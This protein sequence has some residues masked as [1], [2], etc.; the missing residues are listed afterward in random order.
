[1][2]K[3][4]PYRIYSVV[5]PYEV[6][7]TFPEDD[8]NTEIIIKTKTKE[9]FYGQN[10]EDVLLQKQL[11]D[12]HSHESYARY[13]KDWVSEHMWHV[14]LEKSSLTYTG[15]PEITEMTEEEISVLKKEIIS[16]N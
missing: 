13:I 1:M 8:H 4:N 5:F 9:Q 12:T 10:K 14:D 2:Q 15:E 16:L 11:S 3:K 7:F 6:R